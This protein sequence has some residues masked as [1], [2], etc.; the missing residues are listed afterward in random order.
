MAKAIGKF[1]VNIGANTRGFSKGLKGASGMAGGFS[2]SIWGMAA[3]LAGVAAAFMA[4]RGAVKAGGDQFD[5]IDK[6]AKFAK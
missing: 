5:Q 3:K 4:A 2:K 6:I 1:A